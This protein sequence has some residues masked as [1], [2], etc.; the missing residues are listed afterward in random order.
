MKKKPTILKGRVKPRCRADPELRDLREHFSRSPLMAELYRKAEAEVKRRKR[1]ETQPTGVG[2]S[3]AIIDSQRM[4]HELEVHQIELEMQ[5][6]ELKESQSRTETLLEEYT[7]LYEFAPVGFFTLNEQ[8]QILEAN[9]TGAALFGVERSRILHQRLARFVDPSSRPDFLAFLGR[10]FTGTGKEACEAALAKAGAAG[11]WASFHGAL[12]VSIDNPWK[13]CRVA[14]SD[15]TS[16]KQAQET[17]NRLEALTATNRELQEEIVQRQAVEDALKQSQQSQSGLLAESRRMQAQLRR[18]SHQILR[19]Q[20][21][22]RKRISRELHDVITQTLT[23]ISF[24]L[25]T[26]SRDAAGNSKDLE[27]SIARTQRLVEHSVNI[28]HQFARELRPAVLDDLGLIPALHSCLKRFTEQ[29]GV[30]AHLTAFAGVEKLNTARRTAIFRIAQ[31]ALTNIAK[32]AQA[33]R[34]K[35]TIQEQTGVVCL[36][37]EDDGRGFEV[38]RVLRNGKSKR[39]GLLGMR[40][41]VEMVN[42]SFTIESTPE[43]GTVISARIPLPR[44]R[45]RAPLKPNH[46]NG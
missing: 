44:N 19:T 46:E 22:E 13:R 27:R 21:A 17:R 6:G 15:I 39:L 38:E 2:E 28:V 8:G 25:S 14:V 26:L 42:G 4:V 45:G 7:D 9:L 40:E 24:C 41:H 30:L 43:K 36:E 37:I 5:N 16:L 32:H 34:V 18:L 1:R 29:N 31:E 3:S 23:G 20:E 35:I 33:S 11:C 12:S 10:I